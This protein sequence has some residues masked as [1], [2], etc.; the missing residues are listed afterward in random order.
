MKTNILAVMAVVLVAAGCKPTN[1]PDT[2]E[3]SAV[4]QV[5]PADDALD[6]PTSSWVTLTFQKPVERSTVERSFR[7]MDERSYPDSL[8]PV[9]TTMGHSSMSAAMMDMQRMAHLDSA[10]ALRGTFAW[11]S[12][13][14]QCTFRPDS[15]LR[16]AMQ[17][18]I[19]LRQ[20]MVDM[21]EGRMGSTG[22]MGRNGMGDG[23]GMAFHFVTAPAT[24]P[25][26]D[27]DSHHREAS[28]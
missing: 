2:L 9:S 21:M 10:H 5:S 24:G 16:P 19:H 27:H 6:V 26:V 15:L 1:A 22:M 20:D 3:G 4:L 8:C 23:A 12:D 11:N 13:N 7:L 18:M 14:T 17:H 28:Q 25:A